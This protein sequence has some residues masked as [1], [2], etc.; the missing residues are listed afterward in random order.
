MRMAERRL[1]EAAAV[2][3]AAQPGLP[4]ALTTAWT[5]EDGVS[6]M[7][8]P[9]VG[10]GLDGRPKPAH[11]KFSFRYPKPGSTITII[12]TISE[13]LTVLQTLDGHL[14]RNVNVEAAR[15]VQNS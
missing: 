14:R 3:A 8:H 6:D 11:S 4:L 5:E 1:Q 13:A 2:V 9:R 12:V 15:A 7:T 10:A